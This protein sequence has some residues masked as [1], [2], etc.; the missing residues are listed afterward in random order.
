MI[1]RV[2]FIFGTLFSS[3]LLADEKTEYFAGELIDKEL[4][5]FKEIRFDLVP[6][7]LTNLGFK[8]AN[9]K[10]ILWAH[11]SCKFDSADK[12]SEKRFTLFGQ[13]TSVE[14]VPGYRIELVVASLSRNEL[15]SSLEKVYGSP[16]FTSRWTLA[17]GDPLGFEVMNSVWWIFSNGAAIHTKWFPKGNQRPDRANVTYHSAESVKQYQKLFKDNGLDIDKKPINL[18]D[19]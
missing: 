17:P 12:A 13:P 4:L 2:F 14:I 18:K 19:L 9:G 10:G 15:F 1:Q 6:S 5:G 8:C 7:Q 3:I 16:S 11:V